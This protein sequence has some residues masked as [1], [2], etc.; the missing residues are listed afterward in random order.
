MRGVDRENGATIGHHG[1]RVQALE[2]AGP[3]RADARTGGAAA[4]RPPGVL[5][6]C[7]RGALLVRYHADL[8]L[9][10]PSTV[11]RGPKQR[12]FDLLGGHPRLTKGAVG[13]EGVWANG[14]GLADGRVAAGLRALEEIAMELE[15]FIEDC[16]AARAASSRASSASPPL[17]SAST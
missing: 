5:G 2:R 12:V 13:V 10:D 16:R 9:F 11:N 3:R 17:R 4:H 6:I 8:P 15:R 14:V 7:G 1:A